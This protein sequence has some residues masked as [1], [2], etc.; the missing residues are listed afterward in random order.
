MIIHW[1]IFGLRY[2][3]IEK[4]NIHILFFHSVLRNILYKLRT[5]QIVNLYNIHSVAAK[6]M[7]NGTQDDRIARFR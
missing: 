3:S 7:K 6:T 2:K 1:R 4:N 5:I